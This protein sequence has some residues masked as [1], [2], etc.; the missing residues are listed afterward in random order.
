M[1]IGRRTARHLPARCRTERHHA[2]AQEHP[3]ASGLSAE[4]R[5]QCAARLRP[6]NHA[7]CGFL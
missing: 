3:H 2:G 5:P 6:G 4:D 1:P 7:R